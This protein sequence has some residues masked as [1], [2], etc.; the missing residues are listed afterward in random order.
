MKTFHVTVLV[1][2]VLV[3]STSQGRP[4]QVWTYG[5]LLKESDLVVI[6]NA[7]ETKTLP[8]SEHQYGGYVPPFSADE[9]AIVQTM[10]GKPPDADAFVLQKVETTFEIQAVV[11]G[12]FGKKRLI[13]DVG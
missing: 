10:T 11:K 2:F 3:A 5:D 4:K 12:E 13:L 6:A 8:N 7:V 1:G 9:A